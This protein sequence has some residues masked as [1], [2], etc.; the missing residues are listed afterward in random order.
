MESRLSAVFQ[1]GLF[2]LEECRACKRRLAVRFFPLDRATVRW[3]HVMRRVK[4]K[5]HQTC[6]MPF[7]AAA[8]GQPRRRV[9]RHQKNLSNMSTARFSYR[10]NMALVQSLTAGYF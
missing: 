3:S 7:A 9:S 4:G 10:E 6:S 2:G 8:V 1:N 5:T